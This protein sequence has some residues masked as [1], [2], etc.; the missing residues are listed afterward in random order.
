MSNKI[1]NKSKCPQLSSSQ[2]ACSNQDPD[3]DQHS[4]WLHLIVM[5]LKSYA[6]ATVTSVELLPF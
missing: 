2:L 5:S 4:T 3:K 6:F 1:G